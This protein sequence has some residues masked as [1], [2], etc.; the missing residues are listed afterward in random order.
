LHRPCFAAI[1]SLNNCSVLGFL[2]GFSVGE[3]SDDAAAAARLEEALV[4][5]EQHA[6]VLSKLEALENELHDLIN[7]IESELV[8]PFLHVG[9]LDGKEHVDDSLRVQILD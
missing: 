3:R 8:D 1:P 5:L 2:S 9:L 4:P 6:A 7:L